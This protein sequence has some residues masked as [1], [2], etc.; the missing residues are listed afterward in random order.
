MWTFTASP[1]QSSPSKG[2]AAKEAA[3]E[4]R[5]KN[6]V[7]ALPE[8]K[9][10]EIR[11]P[12]VEGYVFDLRQNAIKADVSAMEG[13]RVEP[14]H[15]PTAVFV[16]PQVGYKLGGQSSLG[17]GEF[18]EQDRREY[19]ASTHLQTIQFEITRQ[20]VN[21]LVGT[22]SRSAPDPRG[23]PKLRLQARHRLFPQVFRVVNEYVESKVDFRGVHPCE[24]GLDKY[25]NRIV[26]RLLSAIEPNDS[27]GESPLMPILNRYEPVGTTADV[28]FLT[29]RRCAG[30]EKSHINQV[31]LD[32]E[33]WEQSTAFRLEQSPRIAFYARNVELGLVIGY[34]YEGEPHVYTPDFLAHLTDGRTLILE[35]KGYMTDQDRAK[36]AAARR[37]VSAVNHWGQLGTWLFHVCLDPQRLPDELAS[38]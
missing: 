17:P 4:D 20:V 31:V 14:E 18:V 22:D 10:Y 8:R 1:S 36:H 35:T 2:G 7:H 29:V 19:Y 25:V 33:T 37:W 26:E 32:T 38:L 5:T 34:D 3:P 11:Y 23:N 30:T 28:R 16:K 15:E 24:L 27:A 12:I 6:Y 9:A 13:L 21:A